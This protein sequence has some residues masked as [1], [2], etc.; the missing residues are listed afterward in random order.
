MTRRTCPVCT[1]TFT[2]TRS[3]AVTC[4]TTCR[5]RAR[6]LPEMRALA[7]RTAKFGLSMLAETYTGAPDDEWHAAMDELGQHVLAEIERI[8]QEVSTRG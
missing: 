7:M 3:D 5:S 6:V 8:T 1:R 2:A 4:S